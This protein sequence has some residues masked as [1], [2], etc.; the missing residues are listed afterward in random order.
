LRIETQAPSLIHFGVDDWFD[1]QDI[2]AA[3]TGLGVW[4]A[5]IDTSTL[6]CTRRVDFTFYWPDVNRWE[7]VDF[8]VLVLRP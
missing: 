5:D 3:D 7:G 8:H 4:I 6:S 1:A 2:R